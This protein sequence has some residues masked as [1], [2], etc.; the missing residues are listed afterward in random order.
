MTEHHD[1]ERDPKPADDAPAAGGQ[2]AAEAHAAGEG[3]GEEPDSTPSWWSW[4]DDTEPASVEDAPG[5][6]SEREATTEPAAAPYE[7]FGA[8][9]QHWFPPPPPPP[10]STT[11][12]SDQEGAAWGWDPS[13]TGA[14]TSD[15]GWAWG[16]PPTRRPPRRRGSAIIAAVVAAAVLIASG[17]GIGIGLSNSH[18]PSTASPPTVNPG[19]GPFSGNQT[20]SGGQTANSATQSIVDH[21]RPAVVIIETKLGT[22][23]PG[24]S[25]EGG[26]AGTGMLLTSSGQVLTNNHVIR[27]ATSISVTVNGTQQY[28]ADVVGAD[29]TADVALLQLENASG[30]STIQT[31]DTSNLTAGQSVVAIGNAYGQGGQASSTS[32]TITALDQTI[33]AGDPGS[34][35]ERLQ[36][37]IET[38]APIAPGDSGG[39]LVDTQGEVIGMITAAS[40]TSAISRTSTDGYAISIDDALS[41]VQRIRSGEVSSDIIL[42]LPGLLGVQARNL[43]AATAARLGLDTNGGALVLQVVG[44]TPAAQAGITSGSAITRIAGHAITSAEDLGTVMHGTRP[45]QLVN[46]TWVNDSGT[47]TATVRLITGPAV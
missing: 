12:T 44:G 21:V 25:A 13:S 31:A 22:G 6:A 10:G 41:V 29:P 2:P 11:G 19:G 30:L 26:A 45:G 24:S 43:D 5:A 18:S 15:Q 42:G 47:H 8:Q 28:Q 40:R 35:P 16:P 4:A 39:A 27:G 46:V 14:R 20:P 1:E 38:D 7:G 9:H 33:T 32:G 23:A 34:E 3:P 36:G 37:L 17:V